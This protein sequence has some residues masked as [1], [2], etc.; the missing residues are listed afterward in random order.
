MNVCVP[1]DL[2]LLYFYS[3]FLNAGKEGWIRK[4]P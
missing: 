1:I 4:G 2:L 3:V